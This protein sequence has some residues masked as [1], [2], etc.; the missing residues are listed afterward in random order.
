MHP[1]LLDNMSNII[2]LKLNDVKIE[3]GWCLME[4]LEDL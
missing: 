3:D 1:S 4:V 2:P